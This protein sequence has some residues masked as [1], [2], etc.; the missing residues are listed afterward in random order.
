MVEILS[1]EIFE[2]Y[3]S[4]FSGHMLEFK[5]VLYT[6]VEHAYHCQRYVDSQLLRE[7]RD[8]R[9]AKLAWEVSQRHKKEQIGDWDT[10]KLHTMEELFRAKLI[11][12]Q[13]VRQALLDSGDLVI[14][15]NQASDAFWGTG[16]DGQGKN[17]MGKLW[18][19][20]REELHTV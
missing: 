9:S 11:Q 5:G 1:F 17:E 6:T 13:D 8:A 18:M 4:C 19:K 10:L 15:K 3:F 7:I 12:H 20:L 2:K 14:V 16:P